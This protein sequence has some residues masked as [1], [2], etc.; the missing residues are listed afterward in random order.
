MEEGETVLLRTF[1][2]NKMREFIVKVSE[3]AF[4]CD[5]GVIQLEELHLLTPGEKIYS[6]KGQEFIVQKPRMSDMFNHAKRSGAPMMPKDIGIIIAYT[7][8]CKTDKVL[9]AGTGSG[10]LAMYLGSIAKKVI[11]YEIRSDFVQL[12][13]NNISQAGL[14]N[15]E[16]R[17]G[18]IVEEIDNIEEK[19][20]V[21]TL[22]NSDTPEVIMKAKKNLV[23]GGFVA[24]YSPFIEQAIQIR[25]ALKNSEPWDVDTIE[26]IERPI[27]FSDKGT[28][29]GTSGVGHTGY[30]T[31]A[32]K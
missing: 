29:P 31:I 3:E 6:H 32:R 26:C 28:R 8:L 9:D 30:I 14:N 7:G 15:V 27:S 22:D 21:M 18:N 5:F 17:C 2:K 16:I 24:T 19:F 25:N 11:S 10:I 13:R 12:A 1:I 20:N 23:P 4:H